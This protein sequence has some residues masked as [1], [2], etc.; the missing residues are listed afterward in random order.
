[1]GTWSP[2]TCWATS[3][4]EVDA[5]TS[6]RSWQPSLSNGTYLHK[7]I[8]LRSR[9]LL[10]LGT[11]LP[12]TCWAIS[13]REMEELPAKRSWQPSRRHGTYQHKAIISRSRQLLIMAHGFPKHVEQLVE[14]EWKHFLPTVLE[15][16]PA[17][18]AHTN[19]SL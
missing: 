19:T 18:T 10:M 3:R 4:R 11:W 17:A 8:I 7:A 12:E 6:N 16:L 9:Q 2:E 15:N 1:M 5:L 14:E 13:R